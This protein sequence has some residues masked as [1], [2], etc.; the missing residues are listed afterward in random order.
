M[1]YLFAD[2]PDLIKETQDGLDRIHK[3]SEEMKQ[4]IS[5][6]EEDREYVDIN[7]VLELIINHVNQKSNGKGQIQTQLREVPSFKGYKHQLQIVFTNLLMYLIENQEVDDVLMI[8]T[9]TY[10]NE[11]EINIRRLPSQ[12]NVNEDIVQPE[13][14]QLN[15]KSN[16][17]LALATAHYFIKLH[18]GNSTVDNNTHYLFYKITIPLEPVAVE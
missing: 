2:T 7:N 15:Q 11:I 18:H 6:V 16:K 9:G 17:K 14:K 12:I 10:N 13:F 1:T 5:P 3:I 8:E 4:F